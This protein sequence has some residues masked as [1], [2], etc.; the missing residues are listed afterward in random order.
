MAF[1]VL[2]ATAVMMACV[3]LVCTV[4][5]LAWSIPSWRHQLARPTDASHARC[6]GNE[7]L[8]GWSARVGSGVISVGIMACA[9][10]AWCGCFCV[11]AAL[12]AVS[13]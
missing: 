8:T 2:Y 1:L 3:G 13:R 9:V 4:L 11:L 10:V 6:P 5:C 12:N 7:G